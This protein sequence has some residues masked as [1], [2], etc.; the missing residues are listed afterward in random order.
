M[1]KNNVNRKEFF[2]ILEVT[3]KG[4]HGRN[5]EADYGAESIEEHGT[6]LLCPSAQ[7]LYSQPRHPTTHL[8]TVLSTVSWAL[9]HQLVI[10]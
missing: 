6:G 1:T 9:I 2:F 7:L 4:S 10:K 3:V 5:L 8:Q